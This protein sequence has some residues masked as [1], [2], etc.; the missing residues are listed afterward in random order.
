MRPRVDYVFRCFGKLMT[1]REVDPIIRKDRGTITRRMLCGCVCGKQTIVR[2]A[3]LVSGNTMSCGCY[4][5]ARTREVNSTHG[6]SI[7]VSRGGKA[8]TEYQ[9]WNGMI[10]RCENPKTI[11]YPTY[12]AL[13]IKV[14]DRWRTSFE[15]FFSDMGPRPSKKHSIDRKN[16]NGDYTPD[17]CRWATGKEQ[18]ANSRVSE[19][20]K[21]H[22]GRGNDGYQQIPLSE[23]L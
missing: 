20:F 10:Q 3:D 21:Q 22:M 7:S 15:N 14:C 6:M 23:S 1:L 12:G 19:K 18:F 2:T 17:N 9:I 8:V 4:K 5:I 16:S 11:S 13:G